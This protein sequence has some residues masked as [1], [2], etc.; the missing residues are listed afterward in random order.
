VCRAPTLREQI[1]RGASHLFD[2]KIEQLMEVVGEYPDQRL[3][4]QQQ[5][6]SAA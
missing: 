4:K 6:E 2:G 1:V 5:R 3:P